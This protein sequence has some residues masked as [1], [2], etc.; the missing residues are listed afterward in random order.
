MSKEDL[1]G[2]VFGSLTALKKSSRKGSGVFYTCFCARCGGEKDIQATKLRSGWNTTCGCAKVTPD[3]S[4]KS[5]GRLTVI[6]RAENSGKNAHWHCMC[7]CGNKTIVS[8]AMLRK[9]STTSCGCRRKEVSFELGKAT[10]R[11]GM[12]GTPTYNSWQSMKVR[13]GDIKHISYPNYGGRGIS[14]C[15]RWMLFDNFLSDMGVRPKE[16]TLDRIDTNGNYEPINCRWST[17]LVQH[18]NTRANKYFD[19]LGETITLA[20][21]SQRHGININTLRARIKLGWN[22]VDAVNRPIDQARSSAFR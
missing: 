5:F 12:E 14:V 1:T 9:K 19:F 6:S 4:G 17:L 15:E 22:L 7:D 21:L 11:H 13:C 2:K 20:E 8:G 10:K 18:R 3:I 16:T